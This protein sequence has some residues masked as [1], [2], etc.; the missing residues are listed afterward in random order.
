[1]LGGDT[2][3]HENTRMCPACRTPISVSAFK[4]RYCGE[5]VGRPKEDARELSIHDL[6]GETRATHVSSGN[7]MEAMESFRAEEMASAEASKTASKDE[8]IQGPQ[9]ESASLPELDQYHRDLAASILESSPSAGRSKSRVPQKT[10]PIRL[11]AYVAAILV[12]LVAGV[13]GYPL[14]KEYMQDEEED[15]GPVYRVLGPAY[16]ARGKPLDEVLE[17]AVADVANQNSPGTRKFLETTH[18][19][20]IEKVNTLLTAPRFKYENLT[21]AMA[22]GNACFRVDSSDKIARLRD[23]V[24]KEKLAYDMILRRINGDEAVFGVNLEDG[25]IYDVTVKKGDMI[26]NRFR[27]F[28]ISRTTVT[29]KDTAR[30]S[31]RLERSVRYSVGS[32]PQ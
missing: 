12:L 26:A 13:K 8:P 9:V 2:D 31:N 1:M 24:Q 22:L 20:I 16:L 21:D 5:T 14:V 7:V 27:V 19:R 23:E 10:S 30:M 6:G 11:A 29:V 17:A 4:C 32:R 25:G 18:S 28:H 15:L 3:K